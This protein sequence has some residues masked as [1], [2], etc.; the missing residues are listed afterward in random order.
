MEAKYNRYIP[1]LKLCSDP[2]SYGT[3]HY[4]YHS[5]GVYYRYAVVN[6]S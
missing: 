2:K 4:I 5:T 3:A 6:H 1:H